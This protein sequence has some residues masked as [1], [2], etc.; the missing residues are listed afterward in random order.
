MSDSFSGDRVHLYLLKNSKVLESMHGNYDSYGR[1]F[2][3]RGESMEWNM[4]WDEVCELMFN[5]H[6]GDGIALVLDSIHDS[7]NIPTTQ[8]EQCGSQGWG[9]ITDGAPHPNPHHIVFD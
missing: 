9:R 8:S 6:T 3:T 7:E 5:N 2:N 4:P 1:V